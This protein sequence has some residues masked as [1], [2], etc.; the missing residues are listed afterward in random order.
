VSAIA[1]TVSGMIEKNA[2]RQPNVLAIRAPY[3]GPSNPGTIHAPPAF[4]V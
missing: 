1:M 2:Q 4:G 3:D